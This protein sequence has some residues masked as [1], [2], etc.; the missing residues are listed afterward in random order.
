MGSKIRIFSAGTEQSEEGKACHYG[1][2]NM[3]RKVFRLHGIIDGAE[4]ADNRENSGGK[5]NKEMARAMY[6]Y[7]DEVGDGCADKH[8]KESGAISREME[9]EVQ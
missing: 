1:H 7:I 6:Q 3:Q 4:H 8:G 9:K 2:K 5:T